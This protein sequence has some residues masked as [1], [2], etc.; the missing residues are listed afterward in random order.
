M[1][2]KLFKSTFLLLL[3]SFSVT[4]AN[5][6]EDNTFL[7]NTRISVDFGLGI[8]VGLAIKE[9]LKKE[10][11]GNFADFKTSPNIGVG[12]L[13]NYNF[14]ISETIH[15]GPEIGFI[16]GFTRKITYHTHNITLEEKCA[17]IPIYLRITSPSTETSAIGGNV[18]LG[19]EFNTFFS[20]KY[21]QSGNYPDLHAS[22]VGDKDL[23]EVIKDFPTTSGSIVIGGGLEFPKGFYFVGKIKVAT[24]LFK[25]AKQKELKDNVFEDEL[26]AK[27]IHLTRLA[28]ANIV[29][30]NLGVDV[31]KL[32]E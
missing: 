19:Y 21:K 32:I 15:I 22:L 26:G 5:S 16:Y 6:H 25:L 28:T 14:P 1:R 23:K 10:S 11:K 3:L 9:K 12:V 31:M 30:F 13:V 27:L 8:P 4:L 18:I 7:E 17:Q 29:E 2:N 24:E 20:S